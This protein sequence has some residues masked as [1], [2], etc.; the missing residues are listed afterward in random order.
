MT[1]WADYCISA[2]RFNAQHTHIDQVRRYID[3]GDTLR[4]T[5]EVSRDTVVADLRRGVTYVTIFKGDTDTWKKGQTVFIIKLNGTE[6][7]KTVEDRTTRDNLDEL[8]EF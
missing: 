6:Y 1:K 4:S 5:S 8:P 3:N 7:I 2:V